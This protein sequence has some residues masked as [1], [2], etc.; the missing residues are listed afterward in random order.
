[1]FDKLPV[2]LIAMPEVLEAMKPQ[3]EGRYVLIGGNIPDVDQFTT[4]M[5]RMKSPTTGLVGETTIG[6]EI[7]AN[8]LAQMLDNVMPPTIPNWGLWLIALAIIAMGA[9]T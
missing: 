2:E 8:L 4:P 5:S 6:L 9:L 7:H 1:M 3:I